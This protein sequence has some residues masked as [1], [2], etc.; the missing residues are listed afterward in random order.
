MTT[1]H[2]TTIATNRPPQPTSCQERLDGS[3]QDA[4]IALNVGHCAEPHHTENC[5]YGPPARGEDGS[6][7][8]NFDLLPNG[9]RKHLG[10]D[11]HDTDE[12]AR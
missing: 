6:R 1:S 2:G 12:R 8:E 3:I 10:K 4:M 7:D 9:F 5:H 11:R